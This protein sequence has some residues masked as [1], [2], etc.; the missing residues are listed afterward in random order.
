MLRIMRCG[1]WI[2]R[3]REC[4][5]SSNTTYTTYI[6]RVRPGGDSPWVASTRPPTMK[7]AEEARAKMILMEAGSWSHWLHAVMM[8]PVVLKDSLPPHPAA[9][10]SP[11]PSGF[12]DA[13]EDN[14]GMCCS[15]VVEH[16]VPLQDQNIQNP[17]MPSSDSLK[18]GLNVTC[19][20][21]LVS[22]MH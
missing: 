17:C 9:P 11:V 22:G 8:H 15:F 16:V 2:L 19:I 5:K 12:S 18:A 6:D 3:F 13:V 14:C 7:Q 4:A 10:G 1:R 21:C 20:T